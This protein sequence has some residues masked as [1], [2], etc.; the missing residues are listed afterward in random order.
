V[1]T[2]ARAAVPF[3]LAL[4]IDLTVVSLFPRISTIVPALVR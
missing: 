1:E 3:L 4:L 2:V